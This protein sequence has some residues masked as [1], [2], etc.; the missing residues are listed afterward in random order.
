MSA[1]S[2]R[3]NDAL[4]APMRTTFSCI[5]FSYVNAV[6]S[7]DLDWFAGIGYNTLT[8]LVPRA[9]HSLTVSV[10][11]TTQA[12]ETLAWDT[13]VPSRPVFCVRCCEYWSC[14]VGHVGS[15]RYHS[16][17]FSRCCGFIDRSPARGS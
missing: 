14:G 4:P 2:P 9:A 10:T 1:S 13:S 7:L 12:G 3:V 8:L 16:V 5:I 15:D 17:P 6:R 11:E